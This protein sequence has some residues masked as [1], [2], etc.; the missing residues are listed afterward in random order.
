MKIN[1]TLVNRLLLAALFVLL[2]SSITAQ[3]SGD[4]KTKWGFGSCTDPAAWSYYNGSAWGNATQSPSS[5]FPVGNTIYLDHFTYCDQNMVL[6]GNIVMS[7]AGTLNIRLGGHLQIASTGIV[8]N[9]AIQIDEGCTLTNNGHIYS[10]FPGATIILVEG[11]ETSRPKLINNGSIQLTDDGNAATYNLQIRGNS[12]LISGPNGYIYGTGSMQVTGQHP[13]FEIANPGGFM[14]ANGAVRVT[15]TNSFVKADYLFDG[16]VPQHMGNIPE[17]IWSLVID[18]PTTVTLD[19]DI[20]IDGNYAIGFARVKSGSTLDMGPYIMK[21]SKTNGAA[22]FYLEDGATLI[23][24]HPEGVSSESYQVR[25]FKGCIQMNYADY[26]SGA[27]YTY[28]ANGNQNSGIFTTTPT[29]NTVHDLTVG[30]NTNLTWQNGGTL[31]TI[32]GTYTKEDDTLPVTLSSFTAMVSANNNVQIQWVTQSETGVSGFRLYR[33]TSQYMQEAIS[34]NVFVPATNTSVAQVYQYTDAELMEPGLYYYWLENLDL[35]G[36]SMV[37]GPVTILV[38]PSGPGA[39]T[40]PH[41]SGL[42]SIYPNP[43]NPSTTIKYGVTDQ[44]KVEINIY[45]LKGQKI[46]SLVQESKNPGTYSIVWN[47]NDDNLRQVSSGIY[48]I[49]MNAGGKTTQQKVVI[50]K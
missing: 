21:S 13:R 45:N 41:I 28:N 10:A 15:G 5:P 36:S 6:E 3:V 4:Y 24:Q 7:N 34:L 9:K 25:I 12:T 46:R 32:N 18:N 49:R 14:A 11:T 31:P 17:P 48:L 2:I 22:K 38:A 20:E 50:S 27:N 33:G 42:N 23:T 16:T 35:D 44:S 43:F 26:S 40:I 39:P 8:Q 29:P 19:K 47:G 1:K 30:I 37:H